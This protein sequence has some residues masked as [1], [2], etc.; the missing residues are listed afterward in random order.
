LNVTDSGVISGIGGHDPELL[1][2]IGWNDRSRSPG[3]H[4]QALEFLNQ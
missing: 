3:I 2:M 1:V 4:R